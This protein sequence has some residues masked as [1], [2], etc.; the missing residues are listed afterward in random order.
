MTGPA[1]EHAERARLAHDR[2]QHLERTAALVMLGWFTV[3]MLLLWAI[4]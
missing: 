3:S 2:I 4:T 1:D